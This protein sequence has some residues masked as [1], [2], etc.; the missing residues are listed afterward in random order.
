MT[1]WAFNLAPSKK[2]DEHIGLRTKSGRLIFKMCSLF[3][4]CVRVSEI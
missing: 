3:L 2:Q 4:K 1:K